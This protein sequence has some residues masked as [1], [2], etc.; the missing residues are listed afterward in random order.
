VPVVVTVIGIAWIQAGAWAVQGVK[1][2][3]ALRS[4]SIAHA[5]AAL[6]SLPLI[7]QFVLRPGV[8]FY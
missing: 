5:C 3:G 1:A 8:H 7:F 6:L 2:R 4:K